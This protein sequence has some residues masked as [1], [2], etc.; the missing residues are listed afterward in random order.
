MAA[1]ALVTRE[2]Y[3]STSYHPDVEFIDGQLRERNKELGRSPMVQWIHFRLQVMVSSRFDRHE[4]GARPCRG[5]GKDAG[6]RLARVR[7]SCRACQR[8]PDSAD[9]RR[10]A[11]Y[12]HRDSVS[13][14]SYAEIERRAQDYR[15]MGVRNSWLI[16]PD[17]R[18]AR[19]C[20]EDAWVETTRFTVDGSEIYLD[21]SALFAR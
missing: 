6:F 19:S 15:C 13:D 4:E 10:A 18:T 5:G 16:D 21:V 9:A 20:R 7:A 11:S 8:R 12:R 14:D 1:T 3:L 2:Q 17:T